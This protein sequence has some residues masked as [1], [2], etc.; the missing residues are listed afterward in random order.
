[1]SCGMPHRLRRNVEREEEYRARVKLLGQVLFEKLSERIA[2]RARAEHKWW[3]ISW[4]S[5]H[6]DLLERVIDEAMR[7]RPEE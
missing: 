6:L 7:S 5:M 1:M 2:Q 4:E 3:G